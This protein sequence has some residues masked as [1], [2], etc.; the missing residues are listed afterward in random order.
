[1]D[2]TS[3]LNRARMNGAQQERSIATFGAGCFW[4]VEMLFQQTEGVLCTRVG[5]AGG[6][7][8]NPTYRQ[9]CTGRTGH[10]EVVEVV[11]DP[12]VVT[13]DKL[14]DLF[15]ENHNPT[16]L[17]RQGPDFGT[18]Y[19]SVIFYHST[20]QEKSA[21]AAIKRHAPNFRRRI[22]TQVAPEAPFFAA[23]EYHQN[24]LA[25]RGLASCHI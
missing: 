25:K 8:E 18:Q 23:E 14:L 5:Y 6:T 24:Y 7:K 15:F 19:R 17:N 11:Y 4:G 1:M 2:G 10:A 12:A 3:A 9:V 13:Y 16:T 20:E 21:H 22:V